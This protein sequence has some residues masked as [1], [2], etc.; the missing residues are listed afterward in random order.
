[1]QDDAKVQRTARA[2]RAFSLLAAALVL[3]VIGS[4]A[5]LRL[6]HSGLG[7][8]DWP[9][10]YGAFRS[11]D[12]AGSA[13]APQL[14]QLRATHRVSAA[15]A[16]MAILVCGVLWLGGARSR[17]G[18]TP[19][20]LALLAMMIAL[21]VLGRFTPGATLPVV[22]LGNM[23]GGMLLL[24]LAWCTAVALSDAE[25]RALSLARPAMRHVAIAALLLL[26]TQIV[27]GGLVSTKYAAL[28]CTTFPDCQG[29]WWPPLLD[30][31]VFDPLQAP[32]AV[33]AD[34]A[35][36]LRQSLHLL[37]RYGAL[38]ALAA[39]AALALIAWRCGGGLRTHGIAL[40]ALALL[41]CALGTAMIMLPPQLA[42]TIAHDIVAA[43]I[44]AAACG[45][46]W[47]ACARG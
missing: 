9:A 35:L 18:V 47:R 17:R 46:A 33:A 30:W 40:S 28:A 15:A 36:A 31:M 14:V 41:Q 42:L 39:V 21:S 23:F 19:L 34:A 26:V 16:G 22:A 4:S 1:M 12:A 7:C 13:V 37:H 20:V 38:I 2:T 3:L 24:A 8:D 27:G 11:A 25:S 43:L 44:L 5:W 29:A 10:C 32:S 45:I 6:A